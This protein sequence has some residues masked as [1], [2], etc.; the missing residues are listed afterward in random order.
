MTAFRV[1][2]QMEVKN[3][4]YE[5]SDYEQNQT[6]ATANETLPATEKQIK[7]IQFLLTNG[8]TR[9]QASHVIETLK[10]EG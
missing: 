6:V 10:G 4:S 8:V 3:M 9:K 2:K 7:Y 1:K 5:D